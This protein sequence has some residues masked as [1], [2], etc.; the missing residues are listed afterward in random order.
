MQ[1]AGIRAHIV[2]GLSAETYERLLG[3]SIDIGLLYDPAPHRDLSCESLAVEN[4]FLLGRREQIAA[5]G[6][7]RDL[8]QLDNLPLIL[9]KSPNSRR[10][11]VEKA[12]RERSLVLNLAAE[13]DGFATT[14]ALLRAGMGFSIMTYAALQ[15]LGGDKALAAVEI[16]A[17]GLQWHLHLA[18]HRSQLKNQV[19]NEVA[20]VIRRVIARLIAN[21]RWK[22]ITLLATPSATKL[23]A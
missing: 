10:L 9:P 6:R 19:L 1:Y 15:G 22:G 14:H 12:L 11:L 16:E 23:Q 3:R 8:A 17:Q 5:L 18:Q 4:M 21:R 7:I 2:E 13:V 20:A